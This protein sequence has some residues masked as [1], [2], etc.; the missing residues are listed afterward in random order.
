MLLLVWSLVSL[1]QATQGH[2]LSSTSAPVFT[3]SLTGVITETAGEA[4]VI[5][6]IQAEDRDNVPARPLLY[7]L[8]K[9]PHNYFHLNPSSGE[10]SLTR[11]PDKEAL[12]RAEPSNILIVEVVA[13]ELSDGEKDLDCSSTAQVTIILVRDQTEA[14]LPVERGCHCGQKKNVLQGTIFGGFPAEVNEFPWAAYLNLRSTEKGMTGFCGGSLISDRHVLTAAHC[15]QQD[16]DSG[17]I[18][19]LFDDITVTLGK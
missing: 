18:V 1:L 10:L 2:P 17:E 13:T 6:T 16:T 11:Q 5:L 14:L 3:G 9:N 8:L 4:D 12:V 7:E 15:L 19:G